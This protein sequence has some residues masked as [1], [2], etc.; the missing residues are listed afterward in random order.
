MNSSQIKYV[1]ECLRIR[2]RQLIE[3]YGRKEEM[4]HDISCYDKK[5][6]E[7]SD[8]SWKKASAMTNTIKARV[9]LVE[10]QIILGDGAD[11]VAKALQEL[12]A[13][14]PTTTTNS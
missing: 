4:P 8:Q 7:W 13:W 6:R 5:V 2:E 14:T 1:R 10:E 12:D 11:A 3:R 9:R